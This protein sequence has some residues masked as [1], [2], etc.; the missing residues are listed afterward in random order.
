MKNT[1]DNKNSHARTHDHDRKIDIQDDAL[2]TATTTDFAVV[3]AT[4]RAWREPP[5]DAR[6]IET[7][8][9]RIE[10]FWTVALLPRASSTLRPCCRARPC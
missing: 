6:G 2:S 1:I 9:D 5:R 7:R 8:S 3:D 10:G 4:A